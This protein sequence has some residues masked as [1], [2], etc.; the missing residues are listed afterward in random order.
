MLKKI[1]TRAYKNSSGNWVSQTYAECACGSRKWLR[2]SNFVRTKMCAECRSKKYKEESAVWSKHPLFATWWGMNQRCENPE[3][4]AYCM[5]GARGITVADT[6]RDVK[7]GFN[8]FVQDMGDRP[9]GTSL[10]RVDNALGYSKNNCR[11][12]TIEQQSNNRRDNIFVS[13]NGVTQTIAQWARELGVPAE[14]IRNPI[15]VYHLPPEYVVSTLLKN[16]SRRARWKLRVRTELTERQKNP[17]WW[18]I[19]ASK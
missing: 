12:G 10:D 19:R 16:P 15:R 4:P 18:K 8:R 11:W 2:T 14:K 6:W 5:Y 9:E 17:L 13:L 3:S 1:E 7:D